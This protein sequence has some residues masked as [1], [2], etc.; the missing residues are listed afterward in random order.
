MTPDG[1]STPNRVEHMLGIAAVVLLVGGCFLVLRP[2][3]SAVL[4]AAVLCFSTWPFYQWLERMLKGRRTLAATLM[5]LIVALVLVAPFMIVGISLA[6]NVRAMSND[7]H[8]WLRGGAPALPLWVGKIPVVGES[9]VRYWSDLTH[10]SDKLMEALKEF[11]SS[12]RGW[13]VNRGL[14]LGH[15]I[16]Q[17]SLS[18]FIGFF[19]YRDGEAVVVKLNEVTRKIIGDRTQHLIDV[20]GGTVKGVV[21]GILGT[22][23]AQGF[24]AG[25][26]FWVAGVPASLFLGLMTFFLSFVPFGPPLVW[27][28]A[29][30]GL[31]NT[32]HEGWGIFLAIWGFGVVSSVDNF[33]KP[34]LISRGSNMPFVLVFLGVFGGVFAFGFIG[35]FLGPTLLAVGNSVLQDWSL[36]KEK[37]HA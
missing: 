19:F 37:K 7:L 15:G 6:D 30:I 32:G 29:A 5:T 11:F 26:G 12:S 10:D 2:F 3:L 31:F 1:P 8:S 20:V 16:F 9:A 4:W 28:P 13:L 23:I 27:L 34:Y 25:L 21:Y 36:R 24:L 17:L 35:V 18:V 14:D 33:L 22:A